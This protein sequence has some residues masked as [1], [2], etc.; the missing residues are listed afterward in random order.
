MTMHNLSQ[1]VMAPGFIIGK[2]QGAA[3]LGLCTWH[4]EVLSHSTTKPWP[5]NHN[6]VILMHFGMC[7]DIVFSNQ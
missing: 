3:V 4:F 6:C 1:P 7:F 5:P 2:R